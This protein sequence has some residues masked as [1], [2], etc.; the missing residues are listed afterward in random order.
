MKKN[1][2]EFSGENTLGAF[3]PKN[4]NKQNIARF[5][6]LLRAAFVVCATL[7][8]AHG[9][10][11]ASSSLTSYTSFQCT[12]A[13]VIAGASNINATSAVLNWS[14]VLG[15]TAP[16][17]TVEVYTNAAFTA[18]FGTYPAVTGNSLPLTGLTAGASYFYRIKVDNTVCGDYGTGNFVAEIGYTP[19][20]VT[21]F[22]QDVIASG[23]GLAGTTTTMS[24]DNSLTDGAN[25]AYLATNYQATQAA[26]VTGYGLPVN[27]RLT[28]PSIGS[29]KYILQ[30]YTGNNS[31][32]LPNQNNSGILTFTNPMALTNVYLA[33]A[34]GDGSSVISVVVNFADGTSQTASGL[35]VTNWDDNAPATS[36]AIVSNIGRVKR[37]TGVASTGNFKVFQITINIDA[38]NQAKLINSL[39]ITKTDAGA[40]SKIPNIFAVSGKRASSC[41]E[42]A[43]VSS[44]TSS[45]TSATVSWALATGNSTTGVTYALEVFTDENYT[46]PLAGGSFTGLTG[47]SQLVTGLTLDT[48]YYYRV[49]ATNGTCTSA[50]NA[51]IISVAYCI[52]TTTNVST[53]YNLTNFTT[54]G[55]FTNINNSTAN[56]AYTNF[57]SQTV[58]KAAGQT[59]NFN[60]TK[61]GTTTTVDIWVDW[62]QDLTFSDAEKVFNGGTTSPANI[63][64][65]GTI[66]IPAGTA[67]GNYRIRVRS[68]LFSYTSSACGNQAYGDTEDYTLVVMPQP[69]DCVAPATPVVTVAATG[70]AIT[71]TITAPAT[72]PTGY[73][74]VRSATATL[75]DQPV[76]GTIYAAG[77]ALGGGT[78]ISNGTALT[79]SN[80]VAANTKYFYFVYAYNE[81]GLTCY[82]PRYSVAG[83]GNAVTCAKA[84]VVATASS[85]THSTATL[86]WS[87][88]SGVG[89]NATTYTVEVYTDAALTASFGSFTTSN[90]TYPLTGL[91][92]GASYWYRVKAVTAGCGNDAWS[93]TAT[94]TAQN[95]YTPLNVTGYNA[96]VIANGTGTA[97]LSTTNAVDAVNNAYI[98]IDYER[99][100]GAV[101]TIG[102][103]VNRTLTST[104]IPAL[105]FLFADYTGA[106]ALRLPAQN[107]AGTFLLP[108]PVKLSDVYM[109]LTSGSGASTIT[110]QLQFQ[111]GTTQAATTFSLLDW[112]AT[113]TTAQPALI[114]GI[115]RA[116]R[117]DNAGAIET[118]T[119]KVFYVTLPVDAANQSKLVSGVLITK[120]SAGPTEPVP[121]IFAV[122]GKAVDECPVLASATPSAATGAGATI[123]WATAVG[124]AAATSF[125][126]EIYTNATF[127]T[128]VTGSPFTGLTGTSYVATGLNPFTTYYFRVKAVNAICSSAYIT[129]TFTTLCVIPAAPT[130]AS[131]SFCAGATVANLVATGVTGATYK[132]YTSN[133]STTPLAATATLV[134]GL[135]FV[136]QSISTCEST[137]ISV[138]ITVNTTVAPTAAAQTFCNTATVS[139][140]VA[141]T[142]TGATVTWS[143]TQGG[144]AL[145]GTAALGTGTYYVTQTANGCASA[146]TPVA[147]TVNVSAAPTAAAQTFCAGATAAQLTATGATGATFTWSA[148]Q[149]GTA[150]TGTELLA[151]G[152][153]Y[154]TQTVN[155]C[156][157]PAT[158]VVV[159]INTTAAPIAAAQT[160]CAGATAAELTATTLPGATATW[161][162]TQ[163]GT[164]LTGTE[165]LASGT[166]YV[167]QTL[168]T[169]TSIAAAVTVTINPIPAAPTVAAQSFCTGATAAELTATTQTGATTTWYATQGGTALAG[170]EALVSG[171][172]YVTQTVNGCISTVAEVAVTV[173]P[174]PAAPVAAAQTFCVGATAAQLTVTAETG[175]TTIW[176]ATQGGT[177][178]AGTEI[179][180]TG[181]Y[182]VTQTLNGCVSAA[183]TVNVTVNSTMAPTAS[184]QSFCAGAT[185][186]ELTATTIAGATVTWEDAA[187]NAV[188]PTTVLASGSYFVSQTTNNCEST[189]TEVVV[190]VNA[191]PAAPTGAA[192]Q[193]LT[194]GN[195]VADLEVTLTTGAT[196]SWFVQ[197]NGGEMVA[198][199]STTVLEDGVTYYASQ[200]INGCESSYYMVTVS[201][202]AGTDGFGFT[203]LVV[204][205]NPTKD[206]LTVTNTAAITKVAVTNLLGQTVITQNVNAETVQVNLSGLAA[207]TYILQVYSGSAS[208]NV[209]I[210]KQ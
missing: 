159:T 173:N 36:P 62:N 45:S 184:A 70:S 190:T 92:N 23:V 7:I 46:Q 67:N 96:D 38:G 129:G 110:A 8:S 178:L 33:V 193:A 154:V 102:L 198:I 179:L 11:N 101:A 77:T 207:G 31:L 76:T 199:P 146:A 43:T 86:N 58:S 56:A 24:V 123:T 209:K 153:Y 53:L 195:T 98:A 39:T 210:V 134:T 135:Y 171:T 157:S 113:A 10:S 126:V 140:L 49:R 1:Y 109:A 21:G 83:T 26:A 52:P 106:N 174:I 25:F 172:Y 94:F 148:T 80:F 71:G 127:T 183:A 6:T 93:S 133:T 203:R 149:D 112:Y 122:S 206:V 85:I 13:P 107:Q 4:Y 114:S 147:V 79:F 118:G 17:Y 141:T 60:G 192:T 185:A 104:P 2:R 32:R 14:T 54:T 182:Y 15:V 170:T 142:L 95:S 64:F 30:D 22:T 116:N 55:G 41:V 73:I 81:G 90:N 167:T 48:Q 138:S 87:S 88:V 5:T 18:L 105:K 194:T 108:Q 69:A 151:A 131:Q 89:G 189:A 91:T 136:S 51:G 35:A 130:A 166:Y 137:R 175:A 68:R 9:W 163:G 3:S 42:V 125:T 47:T 164:A 28:S 27:R 37:T 115:G 100:S 75:T 160:F 197:N 156:T 145:A 12:P 111:D 204:Y 201:L 162:A 158:A 208:T 29:L 72:A 165:V 161:S 120:T 180:A 16:T 34:S 188:T 124:S 97:N 84:A 74:I 119:S 187:G 82:G 150:L 19:I 20:S 144:T 50:Y 66:T 128:P 103:P 176:Y 65:N 117:A 191:I 202:I 169:C 205:P 181:T 40:E 200:S 44:V 63:A 132:W 196:V 61:N 57:S 152:T 186:A 59:F 78:V 99:T 155:S 177:A 121:N 168:N 139:Q 143:A